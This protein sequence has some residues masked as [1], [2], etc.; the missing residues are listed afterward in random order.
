MP[1]ILGGGWMGIVAEVVEQ[2]PFQG[3]ENFPLPG[4]NAE[5]DHSIDPFSLPATSLNQFVPSD[6]DG[7]LMLEGTD[8]HGGTHA[9]VRLNKPLQA[10]Q[11]APRKYRE[12][13]E[14]HDGGPVAA[15]PR[16]EE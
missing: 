2:V 4:S 1:R 6:K 9:P 10:T 7:L 14:P 16:K 11:S 3:N 15:E 5:L 12:S 8:S 13:G